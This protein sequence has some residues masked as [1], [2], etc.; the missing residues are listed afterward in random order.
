V[1][2]GGRLQFDAWRPLNNERWQPLGMVATQTVHGLPA[3]IN[4][5]DQQGQAT[6]LWKE[7][8]IMH[9]LWY[10]GSLEDAVRIANSF[11]RQ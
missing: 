1:Y 8:G 3:T 7:G 4:P 10:T 2:S 5:R 9:N 11:P 6:V